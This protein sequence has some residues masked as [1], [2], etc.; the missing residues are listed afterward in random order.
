M[1]EETK[2]IIVVGGG[3]A[4]LS[5]AV[6]L[7]LVGHRVT[8]L[9]SAKQLG[10]RARRVAFGDEAVDNGQHV[11]IG[12]YR[13]TFSLLKRL[14]IP[15]DQLLQRSH[16]DLHAQYCSGK[17]FNLRLKNILVPL[18]LF[19]GLLFAKGF[20]LRDKWHALGFGM[21]LFTYHHALEDDISVAELLNRYHQTANTITALWEPI[22]LA[23]LNTPIDEA[24]AKIFVRVL[25]IAFA[26]VAEMLI[27]FFRRRTW[28]PCCRTPPPISS[29]NMVAMFTLANE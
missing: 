4:G 7:S 9:E 1:T 21:R 24:S 18:N 11:L 14:N 3:W 2:N 22:C 5:C 20:T 12:A 28:A 26:A 8:L 19:V 6:E 13:Q 16:L 27:W 17:A 10:G 29:S 23:S 15:F 25:T